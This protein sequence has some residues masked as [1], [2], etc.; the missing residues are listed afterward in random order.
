MVYSILQ[1]NRLQDE[2]VLLFRFRNYTENY[3]FDVIVDNGKN[4]LTIFSG[5]PLKDLSF[6]FKQSV[7]K[8]HSGYVFLSHGFSYLAHTIIAKKR[9]E[10]RTIKCRE[11]L[12]R[13]QACFSFNK[14]AMKLA[15][16]HGSDPLTIDWDRFQKNFITKEDSVLMRT[17]VRSVIL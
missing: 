1:S 12:N 3:F 11:I 9:D 17:I 14:L 6:V 2:M 10:Y 13:D 16:E 5:N 4:Q 8:E 7:M 15:I